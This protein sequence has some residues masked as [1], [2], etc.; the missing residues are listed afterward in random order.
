MLLIFEVY[1]VPVYTG[2]MLPYNV[3]L[4]KWHVAVGNTMAAEI[5]K[6]N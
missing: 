1:A 2:S 3:H 6:E 5:K 4:E